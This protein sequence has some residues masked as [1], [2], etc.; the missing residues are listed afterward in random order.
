MTYFVMALALVL[1]FTQCK[2]EQTAPQNETEGVRIT[3]TVDGGSS[4]SKVAVN[5]YAQVGYATVT[6]EEG[7]VIYVGNNGA[8]CGYLQFDGTNFTGTIDDTNLSESDY[9]HFYFMG[10]K[11]TT[12][13]PSKV[14]I[15]DQT[16]KY[17]VISYEHS[18]ELYKS[19]VTAYSAKLKNY[20]AIAKFPL[21]GSGTNN[22]VYVRGM[23]NTVTVNFAANNYA[24]S[25][26]GSPYSFSK[27]GNG[28][29]KLHSE[30]E[31]EKWAILLEQDAVTADLL[32]DGF[33][34]TT[35]SVPAI[36][37]NTYHAS[38]I[39]ATSLTA[40]SKVCYSFTVDNK[41]S[42]VRFSKG[43]LQ[44][45]S[46]EGWQLA[47]NQYNYIGGWNTS[48]W[49]DLFG[50]GTWGSGKNPLNTSTSAGDYSWSTDFQGTL[51]GHND[52]RTLT[53]AEWSYVFNS[54]TT[55]SGHRYVRANV[56]SKN[57]VILLPD[58]WSD[59]TYTLNNYNTTNSGYGGNTI[60]ATDWDTLENAGCVFLTTSGNRNGTSLLNVGSVGYYWSST[61]HN[62][63]HANSVYFY[64][65][66]GG[67]TQ[68]AYQFYKYCGCLVRL[69]R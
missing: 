62:G 36:E 18:K 59:D 19:G 38:D 60:N 49:V 31:T 65:E 16:S 42:V 9:L 66:W 34:A 51:D 27:E 10:N 56:C 25:T 5:P 37:P 40:G 53:S 14:Y 68:P 57:G 26:T 61:V 41:G 17:P 24:S 13:Q 55:P 32:A 29:I 45:K 30:S 1:G 12:S 50:W 52:W 8:Y 3:L 67:G 58:N 54:R 46:D 33:E 15:T 20:C 43:N 69:V 21:S 48:S 22:D 35:V 11:G 63:T 39:A 6:F 23:Y 44:Y 28:T 64:S 47:D 2:K 7:D 4:N